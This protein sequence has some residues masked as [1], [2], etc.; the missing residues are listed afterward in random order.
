VVALAAALACAGTAS[1]SFTPFPDRNDTRGP[2]DIKQATQDHGPRGR[3]VHTITTFGRWSNALLGPTT[4]NFFLLDISI[5]KDPKPERTVFIYSVNRRMV[6]VVL[7]SKGKAVAAAKAS[8][9]DGKTVKVSFPR[10]GINDKPGYR[11]IAASFFEGR[12][13]CGGGCVDKV[14]NRGRIL[15]DIAAPDITFPPLGP[16]MSGQYDIEFTVEDRG[17]SGLASWTVEHRDVGSIDWE[18]V[19][20]GITTGPQNVP[21]PGVMTGEQDEFRIV[22]VDLHGNSKASA[23]QTVTAP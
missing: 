9:P 12:G 18:T 7:D 1:A 23:T 8:R 13:G 3:L 5:D 17:D 22:A 16:P 21:F 6:A 10:A 14:R 4:P 15:H 19:L 20:T 2:L 11:W